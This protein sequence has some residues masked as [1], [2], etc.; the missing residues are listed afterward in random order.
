MSV[1]SARGSAAVL[2][3]MLLEGCCQVESCATMLVENRVLLNE[4]IQV[5]MCRRAA[6]VKIFVIFQTF[7]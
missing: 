7:F 2:L 4:C 6:L 3:K 1:V 5:Y